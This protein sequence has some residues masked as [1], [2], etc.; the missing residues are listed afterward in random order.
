LTYTKYSLKPRVM[1]IE[2]LGQNTDGKEAINRP[3]F[4]MHEI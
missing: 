4:I 2:F 1:R 3:S